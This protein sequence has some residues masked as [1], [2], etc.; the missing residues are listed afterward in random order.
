M[1][2]DAIIPPDI[3]PVNP[4]EVADEDIRAKLIELLG[5]AAIPDEVG[6]TFG[7]SEEADGIRVTHLTYANSL[8]ETVPGILMAPLDAP[9]ADG[10]G[11][12]C[13]SGT[14]GSAERVA[15][16]DFHQSADGP[17]IGWGREL[18][19]RGS[20]TFAISAKG[21]ESRRGSA[22]RWAIEC[23]LLAPYGRTQMGVLVEETPR[24]AR[25]LCATD[26][27]DPARIGL[28]G[29]SLG[30][31]ASWYAMACAPLDRGRRTRLRRRRQP[32]ERYP[33]RRSREAQR[34][35][36]H[37][38]HASLLRPSRGRRSL[39]AAQTVHDRLAHGR[40]RHAT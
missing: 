23:K 13:V 38:R 40:R 12:V 4:V 20:T 25:V 6:F 22:E 35:L 17:L 26:G 10:P 7:K 32:G 5:L 36:L 9:D 31:N 28:T 14:G 8:H 34:L 33:P 24:A 15:Q 21:T 30:G 1:R 27:V 37:S 11:I 29:M 3:R 18:A 19:R 16:Q 2:Y 39:Y